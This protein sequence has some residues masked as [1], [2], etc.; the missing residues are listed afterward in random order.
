MNKGE[1]LSEWVFEDGLWGRHCT[2][3]AS[4]PSTC[5][6]AYPPSRFCILGLTL[7]SSENCP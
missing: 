5:S 2:Q 4:D 3:M 1:R 7:L 6:V